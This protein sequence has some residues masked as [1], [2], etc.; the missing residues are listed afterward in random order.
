PGRLTRSDPRYTD[1]AFDNCRRGRLLAGPLRGVEEVDLAGVGQTGKPWL[2]L[3][4]GEGIRVRRAYDANPRK[5][6]VSIHGVLVLDPDNLPHAD[7]TPL[8]I[9]VGSEGARQE[10]GP[11]LTRRGFTIGRDAWF[12]A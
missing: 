6:G 8:L 5:H 9:A 7:G 12:V 1:E 10:I 11:Q 3:L 4:Q 2:R